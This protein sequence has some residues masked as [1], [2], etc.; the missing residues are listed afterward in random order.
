MKRLLLVTV[1]GS[2]AIPAAF[3][4]PEEFSKVD[5]N[6]DGL[7]ST[8]EAKKALP[9]VLIIDNN[10]DGMLNQAEAEVAVPGLMFSGAEEDKAASYVGPEEYELIVQTIAQQ[11]TESEKS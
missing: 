8:M 6:E 3:A 5:T 1:L 11:A 7:L 9:D 10:N 4:S 2:L